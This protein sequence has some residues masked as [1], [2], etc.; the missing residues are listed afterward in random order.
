MQAQRRHVPERG[1]ARAFEGGRGIAAALHAV[2]VDVAAV[3]REE[4][5]FLAVGQP[6]IAP[7]GGLGG[8]PFSVAADGRLLA[9][10]TEAGEAGILDLA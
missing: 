4:G 10:G 3:H 1:A 7:D 9:F 6:W 5:F 2:R 8:R